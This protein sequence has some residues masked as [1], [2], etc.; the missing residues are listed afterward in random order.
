MSTQ[1][2]F[3]SKSLPHQL[4]M[5]KEV[6]LRAL[7]LSEM[8]GIE[9]VA[10]N[11]AHY[12]RVEDTLT[13]DVMLAIQTNSTIDKEGRFSFLDG[14]EP[15]D[16]LYLKSQTEMIHSFKPWIEDGTLPMQFVARAIKNTGEIAAKCS[17]IEGS[18]T[19]FCTPDCPRNQG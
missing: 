1:A 16:G 2:I 12:P 8:S 13:H 3:T 15:L 14:E 11:D 18:E 9:P 17:G 19:G 5:Q 10:T 7:T 6:N 4:E